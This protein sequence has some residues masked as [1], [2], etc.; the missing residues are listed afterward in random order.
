L[1]EFR[2]QGQLQTREEIFN[3]VHSSLHCVIECTF[4]IWKKRWRILQNMSSFNYKAQVQIVVA[5]MGT[6][7]YIRRTSLQDV[8]FMEFDRHLDYVPDDFLTDMTPHSQV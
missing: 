5:S 4:G 7:N 8:T 2:R 1:Q 6:H 3:R